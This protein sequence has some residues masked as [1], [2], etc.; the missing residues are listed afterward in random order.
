MRQFF[1]AYRHDKK[2]LA[3]AK[4]LPWTHNLLILNRCKRTEERE[5]YLRLCLQERWGKRELE[6]QLAGALFERAI[7]SPPKVSPAVTQLHPGAESIFKDAYLFEFLDLPAGHTEAD[8]QRA[9]VANLRKFLDL[10][11]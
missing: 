7:L 3:F 11:M 4:Q 6:R 10:C 2:T 8:L 5:F 1:E 9:L